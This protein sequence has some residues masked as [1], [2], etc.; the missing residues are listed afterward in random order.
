MAPNPTISRVS[1]ADQ[2]YDNLRAAILS[3]EISQGSRIVELQIA[4]SLGTSRAPVREA[5]ARLLQA[6][7]VETRPHHG[8]S[9]IQMSYAQVAKLYRLRVAVECAAIQEIA[10]QSP[11]PA[12]DALAGW[13]D[14]MTELAHQPRETAFRLFVEA[15]LRF[16][17]TLWALAQNEY[18][19]RVAMQ[20]GDQVQMALAVDNARADDLQAIAAGHVPLLDAIAARDIPRAIQLME[21]HLRFPD[22]SPQDAEA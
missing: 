21:Y 22:K 9:V 1:V 5:I 19:E 3:G 14:R 18:I 20:L 2:V 17:E 6:G 13:V 4:K 16:H 7:L 15:D 10:R 11:Y 8:P 12:V